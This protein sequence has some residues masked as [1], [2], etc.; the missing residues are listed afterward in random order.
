MSV[1]HSIF[2]GIVHV[3]VSIVIHL[4]RAPY[5][6][7]KNCTAICSIVPNYSYTN[8]MIYDRDQY[9]IIIS[10]LFCVLSNLQLC[11]SAYLQLCWSVYCKNLQVC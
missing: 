10:V 9:Q 8:S 6:N 3:A 2:V 11:W 4:S 5:Y 7:N 1:N